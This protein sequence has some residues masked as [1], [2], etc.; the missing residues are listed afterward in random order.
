MSGNE[1]DGDFSGTGCA[2]FRESQG[3]S[4][5]QAGLSTPNTVALACDQAQY[6]YCVSPT[7]VVDSHWSL[8]PVVTSEAEA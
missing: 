8:S 2:G 5:K 3:A 6:T 7:A 1:C 4:I